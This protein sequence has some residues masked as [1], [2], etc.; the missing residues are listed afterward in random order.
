[1]MNYLKLGVLDVV[2]LRDGRLAVVLP[3]SDFPDEKVLGL[4]SREHRFVP[5][6]ADVY[7]YT[8][9]DLRYTECKDLDVV[10]L[11]KYDLV[12]KHPDFSQEAY[13]RMVTDIVIPRNSHFDVLMRD[14]LHMEDRLKPFGWTW[15]REHEEVKEVTMAEVEEKFGCK[16]KIV[17]E[18]N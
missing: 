4:Y 5:K 7:K 13:M 18:E 16:V 9:G 11:L 10:K 2:E 8:T 15:E 14:Y 3:V 6:I 1:M 17:K 12:K